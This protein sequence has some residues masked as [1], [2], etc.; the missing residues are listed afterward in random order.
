MR[1]NKQLSNIL[2]NQ[3]Q[4]LRRISR[5]SF[6]LEEVHDWCHTL[7]KIN[8]LEHGISV[9]NGF[10]VDDYLIWTALSDMVM[11]SRIGVED[12]DLALNLKSNV[13]Y[14]DDDFQGAKILSPVEFNLMMHKFGGCFRLS[15]I[16][17]SKISELRKESTLSTSLSRA[18]APE[19][20]LCRM[21]LEPYFPVALTQNFY[22][23]G[24]YT[25]SVEDM[26]SRWFQYTLI[27][28]IKTSN[29]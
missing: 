5:L 10:L 24:L 23:S 21:S 8:S 28:N 7:N 15:N 27:N 6:T 29:K 17:E 9:L 16:S 14:Q 3:F 4:G 1:M 11:P 26:I 19:L 13:Y 12:T 2:F 25:E 20:G 22:K 18:F